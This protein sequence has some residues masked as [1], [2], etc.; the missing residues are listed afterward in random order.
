[1]ARIGQYKALGTKLGGYK[2]TL[3]KVQ[4]MEYAKS[5]ADWKAAEETSLYNQIGGTVANVIGIAQES[6]RAK[7]QADMYA[8]EFGIGGDKFAERVTKEGLKDN[9]F[10]QQ[11][12]EEFWSDENM[13]DKVFG[14]PETV[15]TKDTQSSFV[16][17][18][19]TEEAYQESLKNFSPSTEPGST[20][21]DY[22]TTGGRGGSTAYR[23][24]PPKAPT[25]LNMPTQ[26]I[27]SEYHKKLE[28]VL[29]FRQDET[30]TLDPRGGPSQ[31]KSVHQL[32]LEASRDIKRQKEEVKK[33]R[34]A[35][36]GNRASAIMKSGDLKEK[37]P[38]SDDEVFTAMSTYDESIGPNVGRKTAVSDIMAATESPGFFDSSTGRPSEVKSPSILGLDDIVS[39]GH[40]GGK[41]YR[42]EEDYTR[43]AMGE[44]PGLYGGR[45]S[46]RTGRGFDVTREYPFVNVQ[47]DT[48]TYEV[49]G[50]SDKSVSAAE[51]RAD[52]LALVT[53]ISGAMSEFP[54]AK[55]ERPGVSSTAYRMSD[56]QPAITDDM[57][58]DTLKDTGLGDFDMGTLPP[59]SA[60]ERQLVSKMKEKGLDISTGQIDQLVNEF[61]SV[62]SGG[63]DIRQ[64]TPDDVKSGRK[65][66]TGKGA[67]YFQFETGKDMGF[68][69][70]ANRVANMYKDLGKKVP[71]WVKK[72]KKSGS[73]I[74]L[75]KERQR[76]LLIANL[77]QQEGDK[78]FDTMSK[79]FQSGD[80]SEL[81]AKRHWAGA[82]QDT[83]GYKAKI[84]QYKRD[85]D[86]F[87][88]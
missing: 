51:K 45:E 33:S 22:D 64:M 20:E 41:I 75:S 11:T 8:R 1:M 5:H 61:A 60:L 18:P 14:L 73:P 71:D 38:P 86:R 54:I 85:K 23:K 66:G 52:E 37:A 79:A 30:S 63:Q 88:F 17:D 44:I 78:G 35:S 25:S 62:E 84:Q 72:A 6:R 57:A 74:G 68:E 83:S 80:F 69:T 15:E 77:Y 10:L 7:E 76:E 4:S 58:F 55:P 13:S 46:T 3:S 27:E 21:Q 34:D 29:D 40:S 81:W 67:G 19:R 28:N 32:E 53:G 39:G 24:L 70:G 82:N 59:K 47:G 87:R 42:D 16:P 12:D 9:P 2:T 49:T 50:R 48:T 65:T 26:P 36:S 43:T 56:A 31:K